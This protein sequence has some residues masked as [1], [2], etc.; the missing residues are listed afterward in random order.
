MRGLLLVGLLATPAAA[1]DRP[2]FVF[3]LAD[4]LGWG[5]L[6]CY[7][8]TKIHTPNIDRLAKDGMRFTEAYAGSAVCAP[9]RCCLMTGKHPGHAYVRDNRQWK[10]DE[11]WSGQIPLPADTVT[12]PRLFKAAGYATA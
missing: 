8:Q 11:Q 10:P 7:G 3:V 9:S 4:D 12:L 1:T 2:N 5:D 6:G